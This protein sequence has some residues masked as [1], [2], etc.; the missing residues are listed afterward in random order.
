MLVVQ[1]RCT[2][3]IKFNTNIINNIIVINVDKVLIYFVML[4]EENYFLQI[5]FY[6]IFYT[7][8]F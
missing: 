5:N 3:V 4:N 7:V 2:K 8:L 6:Y 1:N